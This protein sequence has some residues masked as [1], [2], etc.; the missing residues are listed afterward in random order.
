MEHR[1]VDQGPGIAGAI[2]QLKTVDLSHPV[3]P[4]MPHWPG[5]PPTE[6]QPWADLSR[7]GYYLRRFAMSE[8][9]G[10]HLT[11]PAS[12]YPGARTADAYLAAELVRPAAVLDARPQCRSN[13]DYA[14]TAADVLAWESR[15]GP[16]PPGTVA[17]LLTGWSEH[18]HNPAAYLGA[19]AAGNLHFPGFSP[20]AADLLINQR[21]AAGLGADT[22]GPEP[23]ADPTFAVSKLVLSQPR[24]LLENLANLHRLPPVG[25]ILVIGL[26]RLSNASGA[27]AAITA[28]LP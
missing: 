7:H 23:G 5:D 8:H 25:A 10:T 3:S 20:D 18:W 15:H 12:Y 28:F 24:I 11:A 22:A 16:I 2:P 17:L 4:Q 9:G 14:L 21:R 26:L 13:P 27:P 1:K 19:D 6:F